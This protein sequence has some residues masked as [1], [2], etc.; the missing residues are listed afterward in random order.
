[1]DYFENAVQLSSEWVLAIY[2]A[3]R[4]RQ[5]IEPEKKLAYLKRAI[6]IDSLFLPTY[7]N[8]GWFFLPKPESNHWF[9]VYVKKMDQYVREH[10]GHV[11]VTYYNY[12][13]NSL[14]LLG[15][16][17]E[18][19]R[20][21]LRGAELSNH[22][23][24][25]IYANLG[26]VYRDMGRYDDAEKAYQKLV[27]LAPLSFEGY[28]GYAALKHYFQK[29]PVEAIPYYQK[30]IQYGYDVYEDL[31][32]LYLHTNQL[33]SAEALA[34]QFVAA[35]PEDC[36]PRQRLGQVYLHKG[37]KEQAREQFE[38][39][40]ALQPN[41]DDYYAYFPIIA[42][43]QLGKTDSLPALLE[44]ER[45]KAGDHPLFYYMAACGFAFNGQNDLALQWLEKAFQKGWACFLPKCR[46]WYSLESPE[47]YYLRQT[48][49]YQVLVK[50]YFPDQFKD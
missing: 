14:W 22:Q 21:L 25:L 18:A 46:S 20:A 6:T 13:G 1:M 39:M 42:F 35:F 11:P 30:A 31:L 15:K 5:H 36:R 9:E 8:L 19:E 40:I 7:V 16:L 50:K 26:M 29:K 4:A 32:L 44:T 48:P 12:L 47:L 38:K 10:P 45:L 49:E 41:G 24:P 23:H 43:T 27:S 34:H 37:M 33:D 28:T 3:A 2:F 17:E